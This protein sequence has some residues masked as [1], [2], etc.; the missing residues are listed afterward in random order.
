M[1]TITLLVAAS[2]VLSIEASAQ[3]ATRTDTSI[4]RTRDGKP[5]LSAPPPKASDALLESGGEPGHPGQVDQMRNA[6]L[7]FSGRLL[8]ERAVTK[9]I[10]PTLE[11]Y[12]GHCHSLV[13]NAL[14]VSRL[15][16]T[17]PCT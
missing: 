7:D 2:L 13:S 17:G 11:T 16:L 4:A 8:T 5:D 6:I 3:W 12:S 10:E 15:V 1:K 14:M 9:V